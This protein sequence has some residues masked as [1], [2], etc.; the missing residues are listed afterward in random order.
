MLAL[1]LFVNNPSLADSK[2]GSDSKDNYPTNTK[3]KTRKEVKY[4]PKQ[5]KINRDKYQKSEFEVTPLNSPV[6]DEVA[7]FLLKAPANFEIKQVMIKVHNAM[8]LVFKDKDYS[9]AKLV[10]GAQGKEL[11]LSMKDQNPGFY[12][13]YVKV[14]TK[15][16][17]DKYHEYKS[18]YVD[19]VRFILDAKPDGVQMPDPVKNN[20][21]VGGIDSDNDGIRD[22]VQ[23]W[24]ETEYQNQPL[25]KLALQQMARAQQIDL[26]SV[27]DKELSRITGVKLLDSNICLMGIAGGDE[28]YLIQERMD[29]IFLNTKERHFAHIKANGN[30]SGSSYSLPITFESRTALCAFNL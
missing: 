26:L 7:R 9:I 2:K 21:T 24:I 13:L 22:D 20:A 11:H 5:I 10:N 19:H 3:S 14:K 18:A 12:R 30:F 6:K 16:D 8:D 1:F 29:K 15:K 27:N 17:K 23:I 4:F 28:S 25:I